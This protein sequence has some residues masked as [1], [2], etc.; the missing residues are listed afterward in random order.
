MVVGGRFVPDAV[1]LG[2]VTCIV[3]YMSAFAT[4]YLVNPAAVLL[5]PVLLGSAERSQAA[6]WPL[7]P[8]HR[9]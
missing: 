2:H 1:I 8:A 7:V 3:H 5:V 6:Q 4:T 9:R